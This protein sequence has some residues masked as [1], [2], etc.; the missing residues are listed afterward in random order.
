MTAPVRIE[1][2]EPELTDSQRSIRELA[3]DLA[4]NE[5]APVAIHHDRTGEFP[6]EVARKLYDA[7]LMNLSIPAEYGGGGLG[8]FECALVG[9]ELGIGP[10]TPVLLT[11]CRLFPEKGVAESIQALARVRR[12]LPDAQLLI[13]GSQRFDD[14]P[15][16]L[17]RRGVQRHFGVFVGFDEHRDDGMRLVVE[18]QLEIARPR[19]QLAVRR[20]RRIVA[21][22]RIVHRVAHRVEPESIDAAV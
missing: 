15:H 3:R 21:Q 18:R 14:V 20:R 10:E 13:V 1:A 22:L 11:V 6:W 4:H 19:A 2:S 5:I 17:E 8:S 16:R 9:E 12:E 7:G